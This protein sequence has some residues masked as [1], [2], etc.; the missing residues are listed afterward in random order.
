VNPRP[1]KVLGVVDHLQNT[2]DTQLDYIRSYKTRQDAIVL[3][4]GAVRRELVAGYGPAALDELDDILATT[5]KQS[6][7]R[8]DNLMLA[9]KIAVDTLEIIQRSD[10]VSIADT[11]SQVEFLVPQE[12]KHF[13]TPAPAGSVS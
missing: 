10:P 9:L 7:D 5:L 12:F 8:V 13:K 11:L 6:K 3:G 4:L 1:R 2:I